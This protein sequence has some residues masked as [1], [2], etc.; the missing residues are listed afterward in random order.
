MATNPLLNFVALINQ[1]RGQVILMVSLYIKAFL[2][3][4]KQLTPVVS[5]LLR[6]EVL[7]GP[8]ALTVRIVL[9]EPL[10]LP[11]PQEPLLF[12]LRMSCRDNLICHQGGRVDHPVRLLFLHCRRL[13]PG[14]V[15]NRILRSKSPNQ[16]DGEEIGVLAGRRG[17][18]RVRK[19]ENTRML[20]IAGMLVVNHGMDKMGH[21]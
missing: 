3:V 12:Q 5:R 7:Y 9:P 1:R 10:P 14:R 16:T 20:I 19:L 2:P 17:A 15:P 11:L 13:I 4:C 6:L 8:I 21:V 18:A